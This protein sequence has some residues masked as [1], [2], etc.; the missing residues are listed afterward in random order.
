MS[1]SSQLQQQ[2]LHQQPSPEDLLELGRRRLKN[3][4][5]KSKTSS[6]TVN[7]PSS[8]RQSVVDVVK[9]ASASTNVHN[10]NIPWSSDS[11][12]ITP[13]EDA[14]QSD[15]PKIPIQSPTTESG[16]SGLEDLVAV[17]VSQKDELSRENQQL[18]TTIQS[19]STTVNQHHQQS[20]NLQNENIQLQQSIQSLQH[21]LGVIESDC[22]DLEERWKYEREVNNGLNMRLKEMELS[23]DDQVIERKHLETIMQLENR[24]AG[25]EKDLESKDEKLEYAFQLVQTSNSDKRV[26]EDKMISLQEEF[27]RKSESY[28]LEL[29][30]LQS[31]LDQ[32]FEKLKITSDLND[33]L[34]DEIKSQHEQHQLAISSLQA[35]FD[36]Q[37]EHLEKVAD[38]QLKKVDD[39]SS[40]LVNTLEQVQL[41][42]G[43]L[44]EK[45]QEALKRGNDLLVDNQTLMA[46]LEELRTGYV[47]MENQK[48]ELVDGLFNERRGLERANE[49]I[50]RLNGVVEELQKGRPEFVDSECQTK[51][52]EEE[53]KEEGK[54]VEEELREEVARLRMELVEEQ[55]RTDLLAAEVQCLPDYI[56][57]YHKERRLLREKVSEKDVFSTDDLVKAVT[58]L[59]HVATSILTSRLEMAPIDGEF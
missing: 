48:A 17:L 5:K 22:L 4:Q 58:P 57:L 42:N 45:L 54:T 19:L 21:K 56:N 43:K 30:Q 20:S 41:E 18:K 35:D 13:N 40:I 6:S 31:Q 34:N 32:A 2:Q 9:N 27:E 16:S 8:N 11:T 36:S 39:E 7:V 55:H 44:N 46:H 51:E 28:Q 50:R 25:L 52:E 59:K 10:E 49:E 37:L 24:I 38:E 15:I 47:A 12:L 53:V 29:G 1:P 14:E 26:L 33:S 23:R 3:F